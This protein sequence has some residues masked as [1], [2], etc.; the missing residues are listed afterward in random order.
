MQGNL[1]QQIVNVGWKQDRERHESLL[2]NANGDNPGRTKTRYR[3][4]FLAHHFPPLR[5]ISCVRTWNVAKYLSR[6]G[7]EVSVLTP[8]PTLWQCVDEPKN[9][10][11]L[12]V[13]EKIRRIPTR[14]EWQCLMPEIFRYNNNGINWL[15]GGISRRVQRQFGIDR[16]IGWKKAVEKAC[17]KFGK[18]SFDI[19]LATGEPFITFFLAERLAK[20]IQCPYVLDYRDPWTDN[21]YISRPIFQYAVQRE[22]RLLKGASAVTVVSPA[23]A[24]SI[25]NKCK[26]HSKVHVLTNGYDPEELGPVQPFVF[27]HKAIVYTGN[28]YLPK[29]GL[30]PVMAALRVLSRT[31]KDATPPWLFHYYGVQEQYVRSEAARFGVEDYVWCHGNVPRKEVLS[32]V[33]GASVALV[34]SSVSEQVDLDEQGMIPGKLYEAIGLQTPVLLIASANSDSRRILERIGTGGMF[35]A[36]ETYAI[37]E[38]LERMLLV[39]NT[40]LFPPDEFSWNHISHSLDRILG[41][42]L[43]VG[44]NKNCFSPSV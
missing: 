44:V 28:F 12:L 29:R 33:R 22:A 1:N 18:G 31:Y 42:A 10:E 21:P 24:T 6:I 20:K 26:P 35:M 37:A 30:A 32:A 5:A 8:D 27:D 38:C 41:S 7:W 23:W 39:E 17:V 15:I 14:H 43:K 2:L 25:R 4:L 36:K 16:A 34:I 40:Q 9:I 3:L 13:Q 11:K 19:I